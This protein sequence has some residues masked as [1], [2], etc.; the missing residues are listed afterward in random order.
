MV[1]A[2]AAIAFTI[3]LVLALHQLGIVGPVWD[4]LFGNGTERVIDSWFSKRL[5]RQIGLPDAALGALAYLIEI[6]LAAA[7]SDQRWRTRP[8]LVALFGMSAAALGVGSIT[9][10]V[11]QAKILHAW[12]FLCL[13]TAAISLAI[14]WMSDREVSATLH[15]LRGVWRDTHDRVAVRKALFGIAE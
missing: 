2:L 3:S 10:V 15:Y 1:I 14:A 6:I 11:V 8:W 5:Q 7:G 12:C 13:V 9:L 4:P